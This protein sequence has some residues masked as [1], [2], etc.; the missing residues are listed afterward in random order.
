ME[1]SSGATA[2]SRD[3]L[4][5]PGAPALPER[6][7]DHLEKHRG[8]GA[9]A[10]EMVPSFEGWNQAAE[11]VRRRLIDIAQVT[12]GHSRKSLDI[13]ILVTRSFLP[14]PRLLSSLERPEE[15]WISGGR[16]SPSGEICYLKVDVRKGMSKIL[17][18]TGNDTNVFSIPIPAWRALDAE[19][20]LSAPGGTPQWPS[21]PN[22]SW[23]MPEEKLSGLLGFRVDWSAQSPATLRRPLALLARDNSPLGA[24]FRLTFPATDHVPVAPESA[25]V[26]YRLSDIDVIAVTTERWRSVW[27]LLKSIRKQLGSEARTTVIVQAPSRFRWRW[28]RNRYGARIIHVARDTGLAESRNIAVRATDRPVIFL[29]DDDFQLDQRCRIDSALSIFNAFPDLAVLGGNLLDVLHWSD[30]RESE[31]SQGFAMRLIGAPPV[32]RWLRLEDAPRDRRFTNP[33][34]YFEFCDIVDNFAL[35]RRSE[36]FDKGVWWNSA[37]KIGAEHQDLYLRLAAK[38]GARVARTNALKVRN[39]RVQDRRF[40]ALRNRTNR[41]F[42]RFFEDLQLKSFEIVGERTRVIAH[43]GGHAYQARWDDG[44]VNVGTG[45]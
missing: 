10:I 19:N 17:D 13:L 32:V 18:D 42:V 34:D 36:V 4:H 31:Q 8:E 24:F 12:T 21:M 14:S 28:L 15:S 41:F 43:D 29:M 11:F 22:D 9:A 20:V 38:T 3:S 2:V 30:P 7:R 23:Y 6:W 26:Q 27:Q 5:L 37:L 33:T 16:W 25:G 35:I 45:R 1:T 39:V 44:P 40:R